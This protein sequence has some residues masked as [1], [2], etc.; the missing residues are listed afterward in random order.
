MSLSGGDLHLRQTKERGWSLFA[1]RPY[2]REEPVLVMAGPIV[3]TATRLTVPIAADL[4]I[5]PEPVGNLARYLNHSCEPNVGIRHRTVLVAFRDIAKDDEIAID[6]AMFVDEYGDEISEEQLVCR[7]ASRRCRGRLGAFARLPEDLR[8]GYAGF[9]SEW[10]LPREP[11]RS[12]T[13][14]RDQ[15]TACGRLSLCSRARPLSVRS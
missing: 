3:G 9:T 8:T 6:Y 11:K 14:R 5:D 10:L 13:G 2:R 4:F 7:C 12:G 1:D 15:P